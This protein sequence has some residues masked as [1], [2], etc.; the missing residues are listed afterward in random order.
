MGSDEHTA[1]KPPGRVSRASML[2]AGVLATG[3]ALAGGLLADRI[4][5]IA[6]SAPSQKQDAEIL[7]FALQV[8]HLQAAFYEEALSKANLSGE[9]Q[10]YATTVGGQEKEHVAFLEK[11]LG[12]GAE[13]AQRF[14]FGDATSSSDA[15]SEAARD[16]E[17]LVTGA[18]N[19]GAIGLTTGTLKAA[20]KIASVEARHAA[21]IRDITGKNPAPDA[22]EPETTAAKV[23]ASLKR[24][25]YIS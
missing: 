21:W 5:G 1:V 24:T 3:G 7:N 22:S 25:G 13:E 2:K 19:A 20:A 6:E 4:P 8:E 18:Y 14:D 16:L 10:D 12:S 11:A 23:L 17:D 15:F 9:L